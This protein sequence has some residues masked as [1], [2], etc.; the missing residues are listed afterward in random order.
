MFLKIDF[1][2]FFFVDP[3]LAEKYQLDC[4]QF[5]DDGLW[6]LRLEY[7]SDF[8]TI[9]PKPSALNY[10]IAELKKDEETNAKRMSVAAVG[11]RKA[12]RVATPQKDKR[13][14]RDASNR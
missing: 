9:H 3:R 7:I 4:Q 6:V 1:D 14:R 2:S 10:V 12:T 11:K 8:L 13:L 5:Q